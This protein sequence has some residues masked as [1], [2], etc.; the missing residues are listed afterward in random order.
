[1]LVAELR[2]FQIHARCEDHDP[3]TDDPDRQP[4]PLTFTGTVS[5]RA[6]YLMGD[7]N[8]DARAFLDAFG[9]PAGPLAADFPVSA[10]I[11]FTVTTRTCA[12]K[13]SALADEQLLNLSITGPNLTV[14]G[15][16]QWRAEG[17]VPVMEQ[18]LTLSGLPTAGFLPGPALT[19]TFSYPTP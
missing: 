19:A 2:D 5:F 3:P 13:D 17:G 9:V 8:A 4:A 18:P 11:T 1:M 15:T 14:T 6:G 10:P 16:Y 12:Q 7:E